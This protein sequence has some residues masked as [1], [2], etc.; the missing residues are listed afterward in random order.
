MEDSTNRKRKMETNL[1]EK[2]SEVVSEYRN[3]DL[4]MSKFSVPSFSLIETISSI[5]SIDKVWGQL[6]I[7]ITLLRIVLIYSFMPSIFYPILYS[8]SPQLRYHFLLA[9]LMLFFPKTQNFLYKFGYLHNNI[10]T[11][12]I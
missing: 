8:Q 2:V 3:F 12:A 6:W 11:L 9:P 1:L 10:H 4:E 5:T 7:L